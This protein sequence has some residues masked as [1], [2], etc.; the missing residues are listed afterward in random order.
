V[1]L[2]QRLQNAVES[3]IAKSAS[4]NFLLT[5]AGARKRK[6]VS[7]EAD[8]GPMPGKRSNAEIRFWTGSGKMGI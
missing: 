8:F 2:K 1:I 6:K 5:S 7:R 4:A 3:C